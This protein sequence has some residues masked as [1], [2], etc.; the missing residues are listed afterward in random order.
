MP[1]PVVLAKNLAKLS[2]PQNTLYPGLLVALSAYAAKADIATIIACSI[3]IVSIYA[4]AATYNNVQD[5]QTDKLNKRSD[6]PLTSTKLSPK[7]IT[8]FMGIH[9]LFVLLC[10]IFMRQPVSLVILGMYLLLLAAY[11]HPRLRLQARGLIG[12]SLLAICY[13]FL[14]VLLGMLQTHTIHSVFAWKLSAIQTL[15][16]LPLLLAK[17]YKDVIGDAKTKKLTPLVR[18]GKKTV[19]IIAISIASLAGIMYV[20]LAGRYISGWWELVAVASLYLAMTILLHIKEG[21]LSGYVRKLYLLFLVFMPL[22]VIAAYQH[23][24]RLYCFY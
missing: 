4:V 2:R 10:Q 5:R 7:I 9:V 23:Y 20:A 6:N 21:R 11:S 8:A 12:T 19:R 14:P 24:I 18:Y 22:V 13:G 15:L 16:T 3:F 17:D 1:D